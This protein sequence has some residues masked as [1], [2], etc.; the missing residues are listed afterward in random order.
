[1]KKA[2]DKEFNKLIK[3]E[4][5]ILNKKSGYLKSKL[6]PLSE[7]IEGMIPKK[8][9]STLE[10]AF[11]NGFKI[12]LEK[13]SKYIEKSY[14]KEEIEFEH[15]IN[16]YAI[17]KKLNKKTIKNMDKQSKKSNM[18]NKGISTV[19]GAGLGLLGIGLPDI[20][21]FLAM[22]IKTIFEVSLSYGFDYDKEEERVYILNLISLA[23]C[24][25]KRKIEL[26]KKVDYLSYKIDK[27]EEI[28]INME[29]EIKETASVLSDSLLLAKFIQGLPVVGVLGGVTN[30]NVISKVS[31]LSLIKYKKRY[32]DKNK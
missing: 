4:D 31:S 11:Y 28:E 20:P 12:V 23:L 3:K 8:L 5:K 9:E 13:G 24:D 7:K 2:L 32:L 10:S 26:N 17:K 29:K 6:K 19:E 21:L 30:Y 1:M 18:L 16:S 15:E 27:E 25:E 14:N 22:I